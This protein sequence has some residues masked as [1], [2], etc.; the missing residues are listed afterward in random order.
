[1]DPVVLGLLL[2]HAFTSSGTAGRKS[3]GLRRHVVIIDQ[4]VLLFA[5]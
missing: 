2:S 5:G 1:M 4:N 3:G